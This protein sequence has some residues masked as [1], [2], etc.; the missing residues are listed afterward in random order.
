M[1]GIKALPA[2]VEPRRWKITFIKAIQHWENHG[3]ATS[4]FPTCHTRHARVLLCLCCRW[5]MQCCMSLQAHWSQ[6]VA[7]RR[8][9]KPRRTR[10]E[11]RNN[12]HPSP[13]F[14]WSA[15]EETGVAVVTHGWKDMRKWKWENFPP[16]LPQELL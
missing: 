14:L 2:S 6:N 5:L 3:T 13:L 1:K 11:K 9:S 12:S 15:M 10:G 4:F 7:G 8:K 16:Y